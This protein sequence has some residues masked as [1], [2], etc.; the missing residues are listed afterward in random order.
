VALLIEENFTGAFVSGLTVTDSG[1]NIASPANGRRLFDGGVALGDPGIRTTSAIT[2]TGLGPATALVRITNSPGDGPAL[3][4]QDST[5]VNDANGIRFVSYA[6]WAGPG[7]DGRDKR[8]IDYLLV[9]WPRAGGGNVYAISGGAHGTFPAARIIGA[10]ES[11]GGTSSY[12]YLAGNTSVWYADWF[13]VHDNADLPSGASTKY[14]VC[15]VADT[16][17]RGSLGTT[18]EVGSKTYQVIGSPTIT[19]NRLVSSGVHGEGVYADAGAAVG[20]HEA[21][22]ITGTGGRQF[23]FL[24]RGNSARTE[25][26]RFYI[27]HALTRVEDQAGNLIGGAQTGAHTLSNNTTHKFELWDY[28]DSFRVSMNGTDLHGHIQSTTY[29]TNTHVGVLGGVLTEIDEWGAW[30]YSLSLPSALGTGLP[31]VPKGTGTAVFS[32]TFPGADGAALPAAW[33]AVVGTWEQNSSKGRL[34]TADVSG[35]ATITTGTTAA[36]HEIKADITVPGTTYDYLS[37]LDWFP[38]MY[39]RAADSTHFV[40]AR[41]LYQN[42]SPEVEC[43]ENTGS[44]KVMIGYINTGAGSLNAGST[45]N[46]AIA[47]R[48]AEVAAYKDGELVVQATTT[49]T[50]GSRAGI[51]IN[52]SGPRGQPAWD[53]VELRPTSTTPTGPAISNVQ[54]VWRRNTTALITWTT[55]VP[56]RGRVD[57]GA[58]SSYGQATALSGLVT[59]HSH[60]LT[61][62]SPLSAVHFSVYSEID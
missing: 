12:V 9:V 58:T 29:N 21:T 38:G 61:G 26:L 47:V 62:L 3:I 32:E 19:G 48:D 36:N 10:S 54:V 20:Y 27:D 31:E 41:F 33:T 28:G 18:S 15:L 56:A 39:A 34:N 45:H 16:F 7:L 57:Y 6:I 37:G 35:L 17:N 60:T 43:W 2:R 4:I 51:G 24:F 23:S 1:T 50:T 59:S 42:G 11:P 44:G 25:Y 13:H 49:L 40:E 8:A 5:T 30:P 22:A 55:D 52:D 46:L 53:N 14:G